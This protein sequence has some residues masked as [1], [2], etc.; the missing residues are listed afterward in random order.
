MKLKN[1]QL[2]RKERG[3][4]GRQ[5][6]LDFDKYHLSVIDEIKKSVAQ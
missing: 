5:I 6:M 3:T 4:D 1:F 2:L